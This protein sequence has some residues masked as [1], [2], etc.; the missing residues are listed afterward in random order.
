MSSLKIFSFLLIESGSESV[1]P[2]IAA[3]FYHMT[4][5]FSNSVECE[6][7]F[8]TNQASDTL[9]IEKYRIAFFIAD[10]KNEI[11]KC[12]QFNNRN[13]RCNDDSFAICCKQVFS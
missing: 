9:S 7:N 4:F 3:C 1:F 11:F 10:S 5:F 2:K 12:L 6:L 8:A 13:F